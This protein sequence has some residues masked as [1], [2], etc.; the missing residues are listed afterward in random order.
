[1]SNNYHYP[2][3]QK[4][5]IEEV[6]RL[7]L[8]N[9][10]SIYKDFFRWNDI[11]ETE[12]ETG[13]EDITGEEGSSKHQPSSG[14]N[15][16]LVMKHAFTPELFEL[17]LKLLQNDHLAKQKCLNLILKNSLSSKQLLSLFFI[18]AHSANKNILAAQQ[19]LTLIAQK[20]PDKI[21]QHLTK[22]VSIACHSTGNFL[23][24]DLLHS[25]PE[26][27]KESEFSNNLYKTPTPIPRPY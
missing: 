3:F 15:L 9:L 10:R 27:E 14:N 11:S 7:T 17:L 1:M 21:R 2:N 24:Y 12:S 4:L 22:T 18:L 8:Q 20:V 19:F 26:K 25:K 6:I 13:D 23:A 16:L 5:P